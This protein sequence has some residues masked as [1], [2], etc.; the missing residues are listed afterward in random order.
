MT[1]GP[2]WE[3]SDLSKGFQTSARRAV[4]EWHANA[5]VTFG[6]TLAIA[7]AVITL[8]I[9]IVRAAALL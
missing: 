3:A 1:G 7:V 4:A 6:L 8:S 9:E 5:C 2:A